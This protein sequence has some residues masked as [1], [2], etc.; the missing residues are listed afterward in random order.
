MS[1]SMEKHITKALTSLTRLSISC[2]FDFRFSIP[3]F[4]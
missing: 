3:T 2:N 4:V 1:Y